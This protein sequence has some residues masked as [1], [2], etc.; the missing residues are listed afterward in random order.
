[1]A[2]GLGGSALV[3]SG[4][5][6]EGLDLSERAWEKA[7]RSGEPF[8]AWFSGRIR[9]EISFHLFDPKDALAW[10]EKEALKSHLSQA[11]HEHWYVRWLQVRAS[12]DAG[13][14]GETERLLR[15]LEFPRGFYFSTS[16]REN[17]MAPKRV[18]FRA[19]RNSGPR[20]RAALYGRSCIIWPG[21]ASLA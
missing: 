5:V 16:C 18:S 8:A 14:V 19:W 3:Q 13:E 7:E 11:P 20:A 21:F 2:G 6:G 17:G 4:K 12:F 15:D 9:G 1:M 10:Y